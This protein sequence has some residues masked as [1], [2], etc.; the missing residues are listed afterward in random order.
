M[1]TSP[2]V[3]K[4][5]R[6]GDTSSVRPKLLLIDAAWISEPGRAAHFSCLRADDVKPEFLRESPLEQ[7]VDGYYCDRCREGF[8]SDAVVKENPR[9][10][11]W[12]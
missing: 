5:P 9:Y 6:C 2:R 11:Y 4:C 3:E 10:Y 8:V 7:F 1:T 12:R